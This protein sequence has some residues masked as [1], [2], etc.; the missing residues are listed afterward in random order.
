MSDP[1]LTPVEMLTLAGLTDRPRYGYELVERIGELSGGRVRVRPGN[2]YRV[3]HRLASRGL[4]REEASP[5][6]DT[7]DERRQYFSAT[8][9]GRRLAAEQLQMY[10]GVL[11]SM[12]GLGG[13][14]GDA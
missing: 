12:P 3:I 8:E 7:E 5:G 9:E 14:V 6:S 1:T 10:A 2:L 4:V 13:A 11:S